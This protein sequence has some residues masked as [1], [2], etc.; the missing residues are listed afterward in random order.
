M[1]PSL[2]IFPFLRAT[3]LILR[4][5]LEVVHYWWPRPLL[6]VISEVVPYHLMA[7][8]PVTGSCQTLSP[9]YVL[10]SPCFW[11]CVFQ[12]DDGWSDRC[13]VM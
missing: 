8:L 12:G 11:C 10:I 2:P 3:V 6:S 1:S 9:R 7:S 5:G 4:Q 13:G